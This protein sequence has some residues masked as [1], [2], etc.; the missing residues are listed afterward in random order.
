MGREGL[1]QHRPEKLRKSPSWPQSQGGSVPLH[2]L[3]S[4]PELLW[5]LYSRNDRDYLIQPRHMWILGT[6]Q[7]ELPSGDDTLLE[8]QKAK[9]ELIHLG[10][11]NCFP[12]KGVIG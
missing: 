7:G 8:V 3:T 11:G 4:C 10:S 9:Q 6:D 1:R 2:H 5:C 12:H